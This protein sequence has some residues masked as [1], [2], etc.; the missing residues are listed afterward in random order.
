MV[1]GDRLLELPTA[2]VYL[3]E[4]EWR[5]E[6]EDAAD[7]SADIALDAARRQGSNHVLL[8]ALADFPAVASRRIDAE[9]DP[10]SPWH[11]LG[12]ALLAQGIALPTSVRAS[13]DLREFG[14]R[15]ILVNGVE[16]R[17]RIAKT[18]ELLAYLATR[19]PAQAKRDEL[20]E[21]LFE[22]RSDESARAYLR[23]AVHWLR[24]VLP[25]GGIV[26]EDGRVRLSDEVT[27]T[28]ESM[29]FASQLAEAARMQGS[30]R[31]SATQR[32]LAIYDQGEYLPG[33]RS[34]WADEREQE[35]SDLATD[36]RYEVAE[37]ALTAGAPIVPVHI[38]GSA[39]VMPKGRGVNRR[40][41]TTI[42]F[43]RPLHP[44]AGETPEQLT[45]RLREAIERVI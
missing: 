39:L 35:L 19:R 9:L 27:I 30:E 28:S 26:V 21:A 29:R 10:G 44:R 16:A 13:V 7:A 41:R 42:T 32:A 15:A 38:E 43:A 8:Q 12:R 2:A 6:N 25:E 20:L 24:Q 17:P 14:Q 34:A 45:A 4:A 5:A 3:A 33:P 23:Q 36:A 18:Y 40:A 1:A 11:E 22:G 31:I 37:L